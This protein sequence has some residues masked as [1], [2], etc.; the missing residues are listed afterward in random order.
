MAATSSILVAHRSEEARTRL[1]AALFQAGFDVLTA[2]NGEEALRSTAGTNPMLVVA[3]LALPR[4]AAPEIY[5]RLRAT[6][7]RVPP[8]IVL[9]D[10]PAEVPAE[11]PEGEIH[12]VPQAAA[13]PER[14]VRM[15]R[16]LLLARDLSGEFAGGL[17]VMHG[18][19]TRISFGELLQALQ[20]HVFTGRLAFPVT[21][22]A[23]VWFKDGEVV[24][25]AW[26]QARG[27]KGFN[28]LAGLPSGAFS[29]A[30][31]EPP[32]TRSIDADLATLVTEAVEERLAYDELVAELPSLES[33]PEVRVLPSLFAL[34]F[35]LVERRVMGRA[36]QAR[37]L[38]DLVDQIDVADA[39]V[40]RGVKRLIA[41][42]V[43]RVHRPVAR[44]QVV[45][46]ST[47]D[48]Q[49]AEARRLGVGLVAVSIV[50]DGAV[51]RD[52]I[53][54]SP[55]DF[56]RR[57]REAKGLPVTAPATKG[58]FLELFRRVAAYDDVL[59]VLCSSRLSKSYVNATA[60][61]TEGSSELVQSRRDAGGE[62]EPVVLTVDSGHSSGPLGLLVA[63]A[64]RLARRGTPVREAAARIASMAGRSRSFL[65][66]PSFD[67]L[68]HVGVAKGEKLKGRGILAVE[69]GALRLVEQAEA[70]RAHARLLDLLATGI[71]RAAPV[72][73]ALV[74]ASAPAEAAQ[75]RPRLEARFNLTALV[76]RQMGPAVTCHVGPG[77]VGVGLI[78]LEPDEVE[79]VQSE[80]VPAA[81]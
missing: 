30:L 45:T 11:P 22:P 61:A 78:Q 59:A 12:F 34:D 15:V 6:G 18:D 74:H 40:L 9:H 1:S 2:A 27:R 5:S 68:Q 33:R 60:A 81:T 26:G 17:E 29:L 19:L 4:I 63:V 3:Q 76:E 53:D 49:P 56:A 7:L 77:T 57:L 72:A 66:V 16:L 37:T 36:Q 48:L 71:D 31:E 39:E 70:G 23:W 46:D 21:P 54:L 47:A 8:F 13:E 58:E 52:G 25:A 64:A 28:R 65:V 14:L 62:G 20:K 69:G 80:G 44:F 38:V 67:Y 32:E 73:V 79:L 75:L 55:E 50:L 42:G 24:D 10:D 41:E 35:S 43:L 51:F